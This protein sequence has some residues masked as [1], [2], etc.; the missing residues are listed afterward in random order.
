MNSRWYEEFFNADA[1][2]DVWQKYVTPEM[3]RAEADFLDSVLKIRSD[4]HLLDVPCGNGRHSVELASRGFH[5]TGVDISK[6]NMDR[7][8]AK[9]EAQDVEA[10]FVHGDMR[11]LPVATHF[12]GAFCF[13]NSFGYLDYDGMQGFVARISTLLK[14]KGKFC[15]DT[16]MSAESIL[17]DLA[18]KTWFSMDDMYLLAENCYNAGESRLDTT[19]TTLFPDGRSDVRKSSHWVYTVAEISR[20]LS[21][22]GLQTVATYGSLDKE[23]FN[24]KKDRLLLV[25]EK[26]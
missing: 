25:A 17:P 15:I 12:D 16:S 23:P 4:G 3:T 24:V 21:S 18:V 7:A 26:T 5:L 19:Y 13:G 6:K 14:P 10:R 9:A 1:A 20:L 2:L 22:V 11:E 8:R